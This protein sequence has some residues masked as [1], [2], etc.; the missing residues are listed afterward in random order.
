MKS[1]DRIDMLTMAWFP[2]AKLWNRPRCL[3]AHEIVDKEIMISD[4]TE[5]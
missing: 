5:R 2:V 3:S 4:V 1:T